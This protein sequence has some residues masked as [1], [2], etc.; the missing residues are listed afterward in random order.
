M[1]IEEIAQLITL[2]ELNGTHPLFS[3]E[4]NIVPWFIQESLFILN[5]EGYDLKLVEM[6]EDINGTTK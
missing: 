6:K 1:K 3:S 4:E 5:K 2:L